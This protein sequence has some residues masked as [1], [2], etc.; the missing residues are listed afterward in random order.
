[1]ELTHRK[2]RLDLSSDFLFGYGDP[3]LSK[4]L[5]SE[6]Y[7]Y[8]IQYAPDGHT[9]IMRYYGFSKQFD[10]IEEG[11]IIP[12]YEVKIEGGKARFKKL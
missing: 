8:A 7:P 5:F 9:H 11:G 2:G 3:R 12:E 1:M 10:E 4:T 6:F